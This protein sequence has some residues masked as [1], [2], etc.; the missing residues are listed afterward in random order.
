[1]GVPR[2][3]PAEQLGLGNGQPRMQLSLWVCQFLPLGPSCPLGWGLAQNTEQEYTFSHVP[4]T[5]VPP[6]EPAGSGPTL[7]TSQDAWVYRLVQPGL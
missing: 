6:H 3:R 1:M 2:L 7:T 4:T 5:H